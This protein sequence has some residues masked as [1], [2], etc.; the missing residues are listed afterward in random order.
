MLPGG[1]Q[2][3]H[4][5]KPTGAHARWRS[6]GRDCH[7]AADVRLRSQ[8]AA[9][10]AARRLAYGVVSAR[11]R[12]P[13]RQE[14]PHDP[15]LA[16][17]EHQPGP[18]RHA[19]QGRRQHRADRQGRPRASRRARLVHAPAAGADRPRAQGSARP[20]GAR[21]QR[22][23]HSRGDSLS[24]H[25][26]G[27][28]AQE[29]DCHRGRAHARLVRAAGRF[30]PRARARGGA[31]RAAPAQ[32]PERPR[33]RPPVPGD[34]WPRAPVHPRRGRHRG[35]ARDD[36]AR[37]R[38]RVL[39]AALSPQQRHPG[40]ERQV[41]RGRG[42]QTG[43]ALLRRARAAVRARPAHDPAAGAARNP[44]SPRAAGRG[45]HRIHRHPRGALW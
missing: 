8:G 12:D 25:R 20:A 23:H 35:R 13:P 16:G 10:R 9:A 38:V 17:R 37:R 42:H 32:Q 31:Q 28:A 44:E 26:P 41:R 29:L 21:L 30:A 40:G 1:G 19:L 27:Q 22:L 2:D 14:R 5:T 18:R 24:R 7:G 4:A 33:H 34:L 39:R 3:D 45:S 43:L 15:A 6:A 11:R 36:H